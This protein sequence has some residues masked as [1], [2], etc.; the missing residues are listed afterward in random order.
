MAAAFVVAAAAVV[1]ALVAADLVEVVAGKL[2]GQVARCSLE[3]GELDRP[4]GVCSWRAPSTRAR[5][6]APA[7]LI[8]AFETVV[9]L[10]AVAVGESAASGVALFEVP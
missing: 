2:A 10:W 1:A 8:G 7:G 9:A 3:F 6:S 4:P 5:Q